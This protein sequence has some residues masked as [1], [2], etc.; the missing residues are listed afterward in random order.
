MFR[1]GGASVVKNIVVKLHF[2]LQFG[3]D[4]IHT[5]TTQ[6]LTDRRSFKFRLDKDGQ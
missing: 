6:A 5:H 1:N 4:L 3:T 2:Y